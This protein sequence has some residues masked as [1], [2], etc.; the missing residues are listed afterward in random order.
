MVP[1]EMALA[2]IY[3]LST[4]AV[5]PTERLAF[6]NDIFANSYR[7]IAIDAKPEGFAGVLT[8]LSAHELE[9]TSVRSTPLIARTAATPTIVCADEKTFSIQLVYSGR[10]RL[11]HANTEIEV[12]EGDIIVAD[13]SKPYEVAFSVPVHGL[14]LA[15]PWNRFKSYAEKLEA[16]AGHRV[17]VI[18]GPGAV[19]STFLRSAWEQMVEHENAQWPDS[20]A[21][22]IWDLLTDVLNGGDAGEIGTGRAD[23][24]RRK[25][26]IVVDGELSDP[27][28]TSSSIAEALAISTRYLQRIFADVGTTPARFL[29]A[30]R[31]EAAAALLRR[32]DR[33]CSI[34]GVAMQCGF[35]D[36]SYFSREFR[37]RFGLSAR[38]YRLSCGR[39]SRINRSAVEL[40]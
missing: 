21:E 1:A 11:R 20:A 28:F 31:L 3:R 39:A 15:P 35:S 23:D 19:L 14:V 10:C 8:R 22:V 34:T 29:I 17:N 4:A 36:L 7:P 18:G 13:G 5:V 9:I 37:Q 6:W 40:P 2:N 33:A 16:L 32:P 27:A 12:G 30:R 24:L 25:A 26:K 38:D